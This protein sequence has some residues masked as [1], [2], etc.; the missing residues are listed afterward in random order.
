MPSKKQKA[1]RFK[2]ASEVPV[3]LDVIVETPRNSRNKLKYDPD[4]NL[5]KLSKVMPEGMLFPHDFGF[6]PATKAEDGD[7]LDV[8]VLTDEPLYPGCLVE[9]RLVGVIKAEQEQDGK[10]NRNDRLIAVAMQSVLYSDTHTLD[11]LN[12][13][14]LKQIEDFFVNYHRGR[15]VI[16]TIL[17]HEDPSAALHVLRKASARKHAA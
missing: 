16:V 5:F 17:G 4:R 15:G 14:V 1:T 9:C 12:P 8:L 13:T 11:D 6:V 2:N 3:Q 7:P 10:K